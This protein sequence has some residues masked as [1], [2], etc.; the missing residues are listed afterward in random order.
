VQAKKVG[1][2]LEW[3]K[4][5]PNNDINE[6]KQNQTMI[7]INKSNNGI[8]TEGHEQNKE[9]PLSEEKKTQQWKRIKKRNNAFRKWSSNNRHRH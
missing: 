6:R 3:K 5:K 4:T 2:L 7:D 1:P 8:R 9:V